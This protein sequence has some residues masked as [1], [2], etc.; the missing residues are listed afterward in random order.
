MTPNEAMPR[1]ADRAE[2]RFDPYRHYLAGK[3]QPRTMRALPGLARSALELARRAGSVVLVVVVISQ[4]LTAVLLGLQVLF[5]KEVIE[6]VL[7]Q[8][9]GGGSFNATL[10]PLFGLAGVTAAAGLLGGAQTHLQRL[11]GE[12]VQQLSM[13]NI[14]TA[15][16]SVGLIDFENPQFFD[17]LQRVRLNALMRPLTLVTGL[18]Q[19]IGGAVA[20]AGLTATMFVIEPLLLPILFVGAVPLSW[21]SR[22]SGKAEF[23][24]AVRQAAQRRRRGYLEQVLSGRDEAKEIRAFDLGASLKEQWEHSYRRYFVDLDHHIRQRLR[25]DLAS[26]AITAVATAASLGLLTWLIVEQRV[27]I[28]SAGAALIAIRLLASRIQ[29]LF[30]GVSGLFESALF[31]QDLETFL[32]RARVKELN[33][34]GRAPAARFRELRADSVT[35]RYPGSDRDVLSDVSIAV[36]AGEVVALVGENG[37]GKTTLAKLL[38]QMFEPTGGRILWNDTDSQVLDP[39]TIRAQLGIIFQDYVRYQLS[40]RENIGFGRT[41]ALDDQARIITAAKRVGAHDYL[42]QLPEGYDTLLGKEF[43]GGYDLS[44]GQWQRVALARAFFRD[45]ELLVLDEPTAAL[46][47]RSEHEVFEQVSELARGRSVLLISHRFSTVRSADRIYVLEAGRVIEE[48]SHD[49]LM[50]LCGRYAELFNLQANPYR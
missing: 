12:R 42:D 45:A 3:G 7:E 50:T 21:L 44:G 1:A 29:Q 23:A 5:G 11:L 4:L 43:S 34:A 39:A 32:T 40:A 37:S 22:R 2:D 16:T 18:V 33:R 19:V 9:G 10:A 13:R 31:L 48:G 27:G 30:A 46:D 36:R 6:A 49:D 35:F 20:V 28:A 14:L 15:T 25:L 8:S 38:A 17:D 26:A 47:A 41:E 24:F